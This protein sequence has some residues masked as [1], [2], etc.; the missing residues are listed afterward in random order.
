MKTLLVLM[1]CW[2][3]ALTL[4]DT[5]SASYPLCGIEHS[6]ITEGTGSHRGFQASQA[7]VGFARAAAG[8]EGAGV[9]CV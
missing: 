6:V 9:F 7:E 3:V 8:S 2:L 4:R 5:Y 1:V